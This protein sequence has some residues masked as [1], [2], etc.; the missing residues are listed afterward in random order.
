MDHYKNRRV[1]SLGIS[2]APVSIPQER[3][4]DEEALVIA[5]EYVYCARYMINTIILNN[6]FLCPPSLF[7]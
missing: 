7:F 4:Y 1:Q 2:N 3:Y 5:K 6:H